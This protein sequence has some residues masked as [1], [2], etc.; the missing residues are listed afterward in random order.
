MTD[1]IYQNEF[2]I[3]KM[4]C[5]EII[6]FFEESDE[7]D[8]FKGCTFGGVNTNIKDN[9]DFLIPYGT[10][11]YSKWYKIEQFLYKELHANLKMYINDVDK[12][13]TDY[14]IFKDSV[15][16]IGSFMIQK[17]KKGE[18][19]YTFH[20]DSH[21]NSKK[22]NYRVITYIWYL[23]TIEEGGETQFWDNFF[24]KPEQGKLVLFPA[25]WSYPHRGKTPI[26]NDKYIITG[27][28]Y[29]NADYN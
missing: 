21:F 25:T 24:I 19:K 10:N 15:L 9:T 1:F 3:P 6:H 26:S 20:N 13:Y 2:S 16:E 4:L 29:I 5:D 7:D 14:S 27:W 22:N 11:E 8:K 17:Y 18:G 23:N 28:F 12:S